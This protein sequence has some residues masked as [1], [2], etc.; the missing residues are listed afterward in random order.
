M[1]N[2]LYLE[3]YINQNE[4]HD[5]SIIGQ[6]LAQINL[7]S[8][9][10][11]AFAL[12]TRSNFLSSLSFFVPYNFAHDLAKDTLVIESHRKFVLLAVGF[13]TCFGHIIIGYLADQKWV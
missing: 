1:D 2:E 11:N 13:S 7:E 6:L 3:T 10:N 5:E 4:N 12:F 9:K 8:L